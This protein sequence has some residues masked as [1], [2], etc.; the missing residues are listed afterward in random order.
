MSV[1]TPEMKDK[2]RRLVEAREKKAATKKADEEAGRELNEIESEVYDAFT[3]EDEDD[4]DGDSGI[5]GTLKVDLGEPHGVASFRT[6][7]TLYGRV[8]PGMEEQALEYFEK[9]AMIDEV[10]QP[11]FS[12]KRI[13][14]IVRDYDEQGKDLPPGIDFYVNRGMTITRQ[15]G[16]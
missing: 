5:K 7:K 9:R 10:T 1:I 16:S 13:N 4:L 2:L 14:E 15:K 8:I 3:G 11:K 12:K 6:R